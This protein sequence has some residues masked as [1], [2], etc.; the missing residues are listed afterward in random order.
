MPRW[1]THRSAAQ[2]VNPKHITSRLLRRFTE[3]RSVLDLSARAG[4]RCSEYVGCC[5]PRW[6]FWAI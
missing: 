3:R 4:G 6:H 2:A 5:P 1:G